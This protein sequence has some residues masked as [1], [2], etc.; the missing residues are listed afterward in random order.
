[1]NAEFENKFTNEVTNKVTH[2]PTLK[3]VLNLFYQRDRF[4]KD[5]Q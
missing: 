1:M 5:F 2:D 4:F 3:T